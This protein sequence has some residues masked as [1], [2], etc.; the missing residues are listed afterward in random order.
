MDLLSMD[1]MST[2]SCVVAWIKRIMRFKTISQDRFFRER[3]EA[4]ILAVMGT[5]DTVRGW[6]VWWKSRWF[7]STST[8]LIKVALPIFSRRRYCIFEIWDPNSWNS[9]WYDHLVDSRWWCYSRDVPLAL[10][11]RRLYELVPF[12]SSPLP[13]RN[14]EVL[15]VIR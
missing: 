5:L 7:C 11:H 14:D 6:H 13:E 3:V 4:V 2:T 1:Q 8:S 10:Q 9:L 15:P 12:C